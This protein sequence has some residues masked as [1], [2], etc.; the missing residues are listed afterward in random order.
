MRFQGNQDS[1]GGSAESMCMDN[2]T[3]ECTASSSSVCNSTT[4]YGNYEFKNDTWVAFTSGMCSAPYTDCW[5]NVTKL[6]N[7]TVGATIK[8]CVYAND[9]S[10]NWNSASC[11]DPFVYL[12]TEEELVVSF[13]ITLPSQDPVYAE[14]GGNATADIEFNLT[15]GHTASNVI[16][17]L[18][19]TLTCQTDGIPIFKF[20]NTGTATLDWYIY[21][22]S[23]LPASMTLKGD[24]DNTPSGATTITTSGWLV[25]SSITP[26][27]SQN[28]WLWADFSGAGIS[29]ATNRNLISNTTS[30]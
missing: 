24:T 20:D 28:A 29:D 12:T 23:A 25:A 2:V 27:S 3:V 15:G 6:V 19:L 30:S 11:S 4:G 10:N 26:T 18:A 7:S 21:L 16:P 1:T 22:N 5:S 9:T 14:E 8:W 17:C 13:T